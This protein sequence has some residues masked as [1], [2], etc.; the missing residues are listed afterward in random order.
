[1]IEP[2]ILSI[3]M[4]TFNRAGY[5]LDTIKSIQEQSFGNWELLI[6]DDGSDDETEELV[7][8][9]QDERIR[10]FRAERTGMVSQ[11][12]NRAIQLSKGELIAFTDSDDLWA[13]DKILLQIEALKNY[14]G[15]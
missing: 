4:P 2:T 15:A 7:K 6:M 14:P 5:I 1:M 3:I 8:G 12:K 10:Y 13:P 11:L 9:I